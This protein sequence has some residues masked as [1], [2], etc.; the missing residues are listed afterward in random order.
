MNNKNNIAAKTK[1]EQTVELPGYALDSMDTHVGQLSGHVSGQGG[2]AESL[3]FISGA[4]TGRD[5]TFPCFRKTMWGDQLIVKIIKRK[6][7]A[8]I[9]A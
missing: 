6:T 9:I 1:V 3:G 8:K 2:I 7:P 5:Q 4:L